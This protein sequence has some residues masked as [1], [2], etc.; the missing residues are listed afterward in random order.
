MLRQPWFDELGAWALGAMGG[1]PA[2]ADSGAGELPLAPV[3]SALADS[4]PGELPL[5]PVNSALADSGAG[6]LP[7]APVNPALAEHWPLGEGI[8]GFWVL[9]ARV[10]KSP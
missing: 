9:N 3:N 1:L 6:K 4:G 7:L 8:S 2:L 10:S 5:A